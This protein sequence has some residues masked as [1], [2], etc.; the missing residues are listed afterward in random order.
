MVTHDNIHIPKESWPH[1]TWYAIEFFLTLAI[2]VVI[3]FKSTDAIEGLSP[4]LQNW[5]FYGIVTLIFFVWYIIIRGLILKKPIL[6]NR[7]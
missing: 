6:G 7:S 2:A 4:E 5:V 1:W 3:A